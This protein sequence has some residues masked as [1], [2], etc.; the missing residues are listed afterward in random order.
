MKSN[1]IK[2]TNVKLP[3][4]LYFFTTEEGGKSRAITLDAYRAPI[5]WGGNYSKEEILDS[6]CNYKK[7]QQSNLL[8]LIDSEFYFQNKPVLP[9]SKV[10]GEVLIRYTTDLVEDTISRRNSIIVIEGTRIV[11]WGHLELVPKT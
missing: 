1:T 7:L 3:F 11:A 6:K 9:G 5:G 2:R 10:K 4:V 8:E